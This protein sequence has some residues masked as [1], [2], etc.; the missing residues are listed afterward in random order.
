MKNTPNTP[1]PDMLVVNDDPR[2]DEESF[3]AMCENLANEAKPQNIQLAKVI[4][5]TTDIK[6]H[7]VL[8]FWIQV[9]LETG[10]MKILGGY[11]L[12]QEVEEN[13]ILKRRGTAAGA[14]M[15]LRLLKFFDVNDLRDASGQNIYV[16]SED[17]EPIG[18]SRIGFDESDN[19]EENEVLFEE[20]LRPYVA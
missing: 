15:L 2:S 7:G 9:K 13:G 19:Q 8:T 11:Q 10:E 12:D 5:A 6:T 1:N 14:E 3:E 4:Q 16:I 17:D 20:V 18:I